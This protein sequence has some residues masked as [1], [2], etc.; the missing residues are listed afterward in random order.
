MSRELSALNKELALET[1]WDEKR[2]KDIQIE[3]AEK[4]A[5]TNRFLDF[6]ASAVKVGG[7]VAKNKAADA[8]IDQQ[9]QDQGFEKVET[10]VEG[11]P[12]QTEV[13]YVK[14][15]DG[16]Q[17]SVSRSQF[18]SLQESSLMTNRSM[19]EIYS[20]GD[21][22]SN[23]TPLAKNQRQLQML[24]TLL[25]TGNLFASTTGQDTSQ[26]VS[27]TPIVTQD[28]IKTRIGGPNVDLYEAI[29]FDNVEIDK[30]SAINFLNE[31]LIDAWDIAE[32][33]GGTVDYT[34]DSGEV[35]QVNP[36]EAQI[37]DKYK[38]ESDLET[39]I[40][41]TKY[42]KGIKGPTAYGGR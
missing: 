13:S 21:P 31:P 16:N 27:N 20:K 38:S 30:S 42:L 17:I 7:E 9:A 5:Q 39:G 35:I 41:F 18:S 10:K 4:I 33:Y 28:Q 15:V 34:T 6:V 23:E 29:D 11:K 36:L 26:I 19:S 37:L 12:F 40:E 2:K 22:F 25:E 32:N 8:E 14:E 3:T 24:N 1:K